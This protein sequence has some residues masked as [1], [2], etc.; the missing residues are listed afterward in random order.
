[1][2]PPERRLKETQVGRGLYADFASGERSI[3]VL[4]HLCRHACQRLAGVSQNRG[5]GTETIPR[6]T[7]QSID[8]QKAAK[9]DQASLFG[10][11]LEKPMAYRLERLQQGSLRSGPGRILQWLGLNGRR[12]YPSLPSTS[13]KCPS[14]TTGNSKRGSPTC[15]TMGRSFSR[16][17]TSCLNHR[18]GEA[19]P[20]PAGP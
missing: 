19:G 11:A 2:P 9:T 5:E 18:T 10:P 20:A 15:G 17:S 1:M 12:K 16:L 7:P 13:C 3:L 14:S 8:N 4:L 6:D